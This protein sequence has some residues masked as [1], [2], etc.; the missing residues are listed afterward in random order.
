[1][2]AA[3]AARL[4]VKSEGMVW[5]DLG[6]GTGVSVACAMAWCLPAL[7][8]CFPPRPFREASLQLWRSWTALDFWLD[9]LATN[10]TTSN[11]NGIRQSLQWPR[12]LVS[13]AYAV[14]D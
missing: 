5:V 8:Q 12:V 7:A 11:L 1:M 6:G 9:A 4:P 10:D 3:C 13:A 14:E 2:L